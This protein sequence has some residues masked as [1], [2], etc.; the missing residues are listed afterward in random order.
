MILKINII[1]R[2]PFN[3][4][5]SVLVLFACHTRALLEG[6]HLKLLFHDKN[7]TLEQWFPLQGER[8]QS[9]KVFNVRMLVFKNNIEMR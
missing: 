4:L 3:V 7:S 8:A 6:R 2:S 9:L 1:L 5:H